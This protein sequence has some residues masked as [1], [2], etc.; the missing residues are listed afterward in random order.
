MNLEDY[1]TLFI[2]VTLALA[3]VVAYPAFSLVL[4]SQDGSEK[5]SEL[6]LL[7]PDHKA[8]GYPFIVEAGEEFNVF[9][10][11]SNQMV[12]SQYYR[13]YVKLRNQTQSL[14]D[15][16]S[17][18][19]SSLPPIR[20]YRFVVAEGETWELPM[21]LAFKDVSFENLSVFVANVTINGERC[22]LNTFSL[23]DSENSGFYFQLFFELWRYDVLSQSF[24]FDNR[25]VGILLNMTHSESLA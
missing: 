9:I 18:E 15:V 10:G 19:P 14:P 8:E 12:G 16:N 23:W 22:L 6:W 11:V 21:A 25:F 4:P 13:V 2:V 7:G 20:E 17:S 3:S 5:F 1:R 24:R